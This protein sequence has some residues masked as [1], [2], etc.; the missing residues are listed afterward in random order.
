MT[1][2]FFLLVARLLLSAMFLWSGVSA[3]SNIEGTAGYFTGLGLPLPLL[4][5]WGVGLFETAAGA[6]VVFGFLT[7][8]TAALLAPFSLAATYLGHYGQ[9]G[10]PM[11]AFLH[12]QALLKDIAVAGGLIVL[13]IH[14]PGRIS[15]DARRRVSLPLEGRVDP[16]SGSGWGTRGSARRD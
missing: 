15:V 7:R 9:G 13:A 3:L 10:D 1:S 8:P 4:L 6:L 11:L 12:S 5:A 14:G 2:D 16:R